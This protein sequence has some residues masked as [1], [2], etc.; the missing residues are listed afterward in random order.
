MKKCRGFTL[1]EVLIALA[2]IAISLTAIVKTTAY[3]VEDTIQV[4]QKSVANWV[5]LN[6][7]NRARLG[8]ISTSVQNQKTTMLNRT[9][10]YSITRKSTPDRYVSKIFVTVTAKSNGS[11]IITLRGFT[12]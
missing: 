7:M 6:A 12:L 2:I 11:P 10:Y 1:I 8:L 5:A 4:Q 3:D 9:W